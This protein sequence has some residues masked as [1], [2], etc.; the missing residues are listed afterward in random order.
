VKPGGATDTPG[1]Q[2]AGRRPGAR[3][4]S[5][6]DQIARETRWIR[7]FQREAD[8]IASLI[9]DTDLPWIDI[10]LRIDRLRQE[11]RRLFPRKTELF[12]MVYASRYRRL[13]RQWRVTADD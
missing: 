1:R 12:E 6:Q 7:R 8:E 4:E 3:L 5:R 2:P 10:E 9:L 11:A 13:W